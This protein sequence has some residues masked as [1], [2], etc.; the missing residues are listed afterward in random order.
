[1]GEEDQEGNWAAGTFTAPPVSL[2]FPATLHP[3]NTP[4]EGGFL[5]SQ[6]G[7]LR[8]VAPFQGSPVGFES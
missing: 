7:H 4:P 6:L 2:G 3:L 1:M 5:E 8:R